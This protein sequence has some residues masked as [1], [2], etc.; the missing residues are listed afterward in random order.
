MPADRDCD[1]VPGRQ[2]LAASSDCRAAKQGGV[3]SCAAGPDPA[4]A[5]RGADRARQ[6]ARV[7][8]E[9]CAAARRSAG[10]Q[11]VRLR[12]NDVQCRV[13]HRPG[14]RRR[15]RKRRIF[16]RSVRRAEESRQ[17]GCRPRETGNPHHAAQRRRR[18]GPAVRIAGLHRAAAR[19]R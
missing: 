2:L 9:V 16:H 10:A 3:D 17:T 6:T 12:Q 11:H 18:R 14:S 5:G 7:A 1:G 19:A 8:D 15:R 4:A 13:S